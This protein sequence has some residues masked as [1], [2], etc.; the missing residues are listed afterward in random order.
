MK[1]PGLLLVALFASVARLSAQVTV[2]VTT[3]QEQF[4]PGETLPTA[5][6]IVNRS[7]Q[8]L[9]LGADEGWLTFS[10]ESPD[11]FVVF[12]KGEVPVRGEFTLESSER[13]TKR[14]DLA[15]YFNLLKPGRY[16]IRATIRIKEWEDRQVSSPPKSFDIIQGAKI[17]EQEFGVP[18]VP[19]I[20]NG[21]PEVRTYALQQ[22]NYL[23]T[24][25]KLYVQITDTKGKINKVF[26]IGPMLSFGQ[27]EPQ[28]DKLSNLHILYQ[29]GPHSFSYTVI[30]PDGE[31]IVRQTYDYTSRP[32]LKAD[33]NGNLA[34][35]GGTRRVT[36]DDLPRPQALENN[37]KTTTP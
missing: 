23:R 28:L 36:F 17:W 24:Q 30:T 33:A 29:N 14:V 7:G 31:V 3:E 19:G 34:V 25:L 16:A 15:P 8:T 1:N 10:V 21:M 35:I 27:P 12:K 20:T 37:V 11:G 26:P 4:L 22:A 2:E 9:H 13:A 6:R 18:R 5:A 32:R